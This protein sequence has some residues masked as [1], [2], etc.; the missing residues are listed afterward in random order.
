MELGQ[1]TVNY[2]ETISNKASFD[3]LH[4]KQSGGAGQ[5][6]RVIGE[7]DLLPSEEGEF[8]NQ[9]VN[10]VVG[11]SVPIEYI[12]AVEKAFYECVKKGPLTGYPVVNVKYTLEGGV[13][14]P[15]DSSQNAFQAATKY[16]FA[17]AM[18]KANAL[19]MEPIMSVEVSCPKE[20]YTSV[21]AGLSKRRGLMT[22]TET[23][24]DL[25]ILQADVPLAN[26]FGYATELRGNT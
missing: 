25:Y 4:K 11:G 14:H 19:I 10:K 2:R 1:P 16:S 9:F 24:G 7:I 8:G 21:M 23:R 3:Y 6:A 15:V 18:D 26:M 22:N 20:T 13:T 12:T 17:F 5:Y